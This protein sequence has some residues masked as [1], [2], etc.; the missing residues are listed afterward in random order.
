MHRFFIPEASFVPGQVIELPED[1]LRHLRTVLRLTSGAE[2]ELLDGVGLVARGKILDDYTVRVLVVE[3][4]PNLSCHLSLI[5][6]LAKGEK[7]E[8]VLQKCTELGVNRFLPTQMQRSVGRIK[9]EREPKRIKR[10]Q[11]IIQEAA[12]QSGQAYLPDLQVEHN[13]DAAIDA[14]DADL[15]L[16]LWEGSAQPLGQILP[17]NCPERVAVIVGPEG[18]ITEEEAQKAERAGYQPVSIGPRILR[19]ETAGLAIMTI[20]QYLYGDL[21]KGRCSMNAVSQGKDES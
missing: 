17:D 2:C 1:V 3:Q 9:P 19:T 5:Q 15:K 6:G 13:L 7:L 4:A 12:R 21:A 20:L 16:L 14:V 18:G 11:K 10:W 8:L